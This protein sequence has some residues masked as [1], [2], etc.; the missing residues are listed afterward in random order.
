MA[1]QF[2]EADVR[3]SLLRGFYTLSGKASHDERFQSVRDPGPPPKSSAPKRPAWL[4]E[5]DLDSFAADFQR[6]GFTGALNYY[7]NMDRSWALTPFLDGARI[8]QPALFIAGEKDPVLEFHRREFETLETNVPN[9]RQKI[10]LPGVGH[11]TQQEAHGAVNQLLIEFL[12]L[13]QQ[14]ES[15]AG[16]QSNAIAANP[17]V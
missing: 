17:Q 1:E 7:R 13:V 16:R 9:L 6:T 14:I 3:A 10:L 4:S 2:L 12:N 8:L 5:T 15:M 11:W